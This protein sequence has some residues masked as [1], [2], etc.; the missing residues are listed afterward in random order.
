MAAGSVHLQTWP[1]AADLGDA[2]ATTRRARRRR[3]RARGRPRRK[4]DRE[5]GHAHPGGAGDD[6]RPGRALEAI[7]GAERDLR[8]V[9][10]ITGGL[11]L[12]AAEDSEIL[13]DAVLG[14]PPPKR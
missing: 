13:V 4:V 8:A 2:A 10:S 12:V 1:T 6:H 14:A 7:R 11:H 3:G 9:G 5:G